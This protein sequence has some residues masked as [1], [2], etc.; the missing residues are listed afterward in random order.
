[1]DGC[2]VCVCVCVRACLCVSVHVYAEYFVE[3]IIVYIKHWVKGIA[4]LF[5]F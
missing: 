3:L 5:G 2:I 4:L 1:M